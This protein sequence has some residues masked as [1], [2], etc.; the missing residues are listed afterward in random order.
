MLLASVLTAEKQKHTAIAATIQY[1][2][3]CVLLGDCADIFPPCC[4]YSYVLTLNYVVFTRSRVNI[5]SGATPHTDNSDNIKFPP[6]EQNFN[7]EILSHS[8]IATWFVTKSYY[9]ELRCMA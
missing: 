5:A 7:L 4:L 8:S 6:E 2:G 1:Q 9:Y 3:R